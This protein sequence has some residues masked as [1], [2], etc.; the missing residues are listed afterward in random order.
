M[1][2]PD[3]VEAALARIADGAPVDWERLRREAR[4][5]DDDRRALE[6][7]AR[8]RAA[9]REA[10]EHAPAHSSEGGYEI[11]GLLGEGAQAR[12]YRARDRVLGREVA[13]KE[14]RLAGDLPPGAGARFL[15]EAR[16]LARVDHPN[17]VRIHSVEEVDGRIRIALERIE[18]RTLAE[19][20]AR[21]GP[22]APGEA[23]RVGIELCRGLAA[24]HAQGLVH[25]DVKP[26]NAMRAVGGRI[27]LLDFGV[28]R[29]ARSVAWPR[30]G[31]EGGTPLFMAPE[32]L[33][34]GGEESA[35]SDLYALGVTLYWLVSGAYPWAE[36]GRL[37]Q[38]EEL[39]ARVHRGERVPLLDRVPD[40]PARFAEIV[41]RAIALDPAQRFSSAGAME[42]ALR[43]LQADGNGPR[44]RLPAAG[45]S[46]RAWLV[47]ALVVGI[48]GSVLGARSVLAGRTLHATTRLF[49]LRDGGEHALADGDAIRLGDGLVMEARAPDDF[50]LYVF[51]EDDRGRWHALFPLH[52]VL[53]ANP[54]RGLRAHRL[55]GAREGVSLAWEVDSAAGTER[56]LTIASRGPSAAGEALRREIPEATQG[57]DGA[58]TLSGS[59]RAL[60]LRGVGATRALGEGAPPEPP[61]SLAELFRGRVDAGDASRD[62]VWSL[63]TLRHEHESA[64]RR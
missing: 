10:H 20:V 11:L 8:I 36:P 50:W 44:A 18:G 51:N 28:A 61:L 43:S 2:L 22:L 29:R 26:A 53:P 34:P 4:L 33:E 27:V 52:G 19:V 59:T 9:G 30:R 48:A 15:A 6:L 46:R 32:L 12:V 3:P 47:A 23:A 7:L 25:G 62:E 31:S 60:L 38:L 63:V 24:V 41:A 35:S 16:H 17:V 40:V 5:G 1:G 37:P 45:G 64:E 55:P 14:L 56:F 42:E 49:V 57:G 58:V 13:L 21:D 39:L 54:L